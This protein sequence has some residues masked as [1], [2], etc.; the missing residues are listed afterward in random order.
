M[1]GRCVLGIE[2]AGQVRVGPCRRSTDIAS[3]SSGVDAFASTVL[4][5]RK[6]PMP[7][8]LLTDPGLPVEQALSGYERLRRPA[9][10]ELQYRSFN[11]A[12]DLV[13]PPLKALM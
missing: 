11:A 7:A 8:A 1:H 9:A 10:Q 4:W 3:I 6:T 13:P 5:V 12:R 2:C